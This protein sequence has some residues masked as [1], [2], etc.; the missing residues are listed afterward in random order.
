MRM[1][2]DERRRRAKN[3]MRLKRGG[4]EIDF[5]APKDGKLHHCLMPFVAEKNP[6]IVR[7]VVTKREAAAMRNEPLERKPRQKKPPKKDD[8]QTTMGF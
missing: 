5:P 7:E 8:G 1:S 4:E 2:D 3:R 6:C